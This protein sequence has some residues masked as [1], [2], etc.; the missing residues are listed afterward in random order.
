[1]KTDADKAMA[2]RASLEAGGVMQ[3]ALRRFPALYDNP[4]ACE[5]LAWIETQLVEESMASDEALEKAVQEAQ[6]EQARETIGEIKW[7]VD[8]SNL[9]NGHYA[10]DL[11]AACRELSMILPERGEKVAAKVTKDKLAAQARE[12]WEAADLLLDAL[13]TALEVDQKTEAWGCHHENP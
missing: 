10:S 7:K 4:V 5:A 2:A 8:A 1:M 12:V 11:A 6:E 13:A 9:P 3:D